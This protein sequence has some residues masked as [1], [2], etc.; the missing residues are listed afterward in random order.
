MFW[1]HLTSPL[2]VF[3]RTRLGRFPLFSAFPA[4]LQVSARC[5]EVLRRADARE[6]VPKPW[7]LNYPSK[8]PLSHLPSLPGACA[9]Y[10]TTDIEAQRLICLCS[11]FARRCDCHY[12]RVFSAISA[13][14]RQRPY[15]SLY[16]VIAHSWCAAAESHVPATSPAVSHSRD[17]T[18]PL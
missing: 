12:L 7:N 17:E 10:W 6:A 9:R 13:D 8:T 11:S 4:S 3:P 15:D 5:P 1:A 16:A 2:L 18:L 14:V